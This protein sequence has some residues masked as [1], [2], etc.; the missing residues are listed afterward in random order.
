[1]STGKSIWRKAGYRSRK[2]AVTEG[3]ELLDEA[4]RE[5]RHVLA[6][7][8]RQEIV[9]NDGQR[10]LI[11]GRLGIKEAISPIAIHLVGVDAI[12]TAV[13]YLDHRESRSDLP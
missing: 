1:M 7:V 6:V 2:Q 11:I 8:G 9:K 12:F 4:T 13:R 3:F 5:V 10:V